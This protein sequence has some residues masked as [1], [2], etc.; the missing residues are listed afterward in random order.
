MPETGM[1]PEALTQ[2]YQDNDAAIQ[3]ELN[4]GA[5]G[6]HSR[7]ISRKVLAS[8]NKIEDGGIVPVYKRTNLILAD[9]GTKALPD[10]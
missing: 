5:L 10:A 3:I 4:G 9:T 2:V 6:S 1:H 7:H 8:R